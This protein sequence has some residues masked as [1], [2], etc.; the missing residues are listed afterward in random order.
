MSA[1]SSEH[2]TGL[3][4]RNII[5]RIMMGILSIATR[6][7]SCSQAYVFG[8]ALHS[9]APND[10]DLLVV[11]DPDACPP[12]DAYKRHAELC[13]SLKAALGLPV[14]LTPLTQ[15]EAKSVSFVERMNAI[16]LE[17]ALRE[18]RKL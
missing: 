3:N 2:Y 10:L 18:L 12:S 15:D 9:A 6:I 11:Y 8:S 4:Q 5:E 14:H 13:E 16:P 17:E 7:P 1:S